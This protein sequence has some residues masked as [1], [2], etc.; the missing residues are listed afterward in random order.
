VGG[1]DNP[2][3]YRSERAAQLPG[4]GLGVAI[5]Q[6]LVQQMGGALALRSEPGQG[7]AFTIRLPMSEIAHT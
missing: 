4:I 7:A 6:L 1:G 2:P 3:Y 5:S